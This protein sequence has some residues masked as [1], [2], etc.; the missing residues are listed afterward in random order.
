MP[1]FATAIPGLMQLFTP[2]IRQEAER[3][4]DDDAVMSLDLDEVEAVA[5]VALDDITVGARWVKLEEGW[6]GQTDAVDEVK[7][8]VLCAVLVAAGRRTTAPTEADIEAEEEDF[9]EWLER[10]LSRKVTE[11]E[12]NYLEKVEKRFR[13]V[14]QTGEIFDQDMVRLHP[15][16]NIESM[17][18]L[19]LWPQ[20]PRTLREFWGY[21]ALALNEKGLAVP[22]FLLKAAA[23]DKG[24]RRLAEW[25]RTL[26]L[27]R[28][29]ERVRALARALDSDEADDDEDAAPVVGKAA[30]L[31]VTTSELKLQMVSAAGIF[32][33]VMPADLA[34]LGARLDAGKLPLD[35]A[36]A[37]LLR[38]C[39]EGQRASGSALFR[40]DHGA[41]VRLL[42]AVLAQPELAPRVVTLDGVPLRQDTRALLWAAKEVGDELELRLVQEDG[43]S[44]PMP[45]RVL[46]GATTHYLSDEAVMPGPVWFGDD[47]RV[48]GPLLVPMKALISEDGVLFLEKLGVALP[49]TMAERVVHEPLQVRVRAGCL[50]K[51]ATSGAEYAV[52]Q[53]EAVDGEGRL[54]ERLRGDGWSEAGPLLPND[55]E[56]IILRDRDMLGMAERALTAFRSTFDPEHQGFR[57]RLT[58][59]FPDQFH[60]WAKSLPEAMEL[61][62]DERLQSILADP[63]IARVKLEARQTESIDWFDLR[64]MFEIEGTELKPAEIRRLVAARGGF[65]RLADGS[66]KRVELQLSDE[67][68]VMIDQLGI[69][70]EELGD[71]SHRLHWRQL[72]NEKTA[73]LIHPQAWQAVSR[74]LEAAELMEKPAV[75]KELQLTLRPYQ[76]EGF[77]FLSY[78]TLNRF[79]GILADDMGLG[80]TVQSITWLLWLRGEQPPGE[81]PPPC[82]VVCPKSV[83]D[84]W[85]AEL[86]KTAP[87]LLVQVLREKDELDMVWLTERLDVLVINYAQLRGLIEDLKHVHFLA[88]ILDEGQ[89]IKNPDSQAARAAR[90][91]HAFN[92]LV[93]TG[94]PLENRLLD[95]W[96]LMTFATPGALGDR[97]YFQKHFDR[98]KDGRASAR[99]SARLR[100]FLLRRT[101]GQVAGDLPPRSEEAMIC[102]MTAEQSAAYQAEL[103]RAQQMVLTAAT[104]DALNKNRFAILQ[105]LTRLRQICCHPSLVGAGNDDGAKLTAVLELIEELHAEGHK[106]LLFSQFVRMLTIL[107][108][109]LEKMDI[110][111]HWLTGA[112]NDR[113]SVVKAFQEDEK[114]SVFLLSLK[115]GGSGLNLTAA[116]YV[117]L[118]DPW[119]NPAVEAQAID[120]AHRIGQTQPVMAYR[121]ITKGT[122]EEKILTLQQKKQMM[123]ANILGEEGFSKSLG[124]DDFAYLFDLEREES[125]WQ[126]EL[127][128]VD[129]K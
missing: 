22:R 9:V 69:E 30:R 124:R 118:Y 82:L 20:R 96:S 108:E 10:D 84:V 2:E 90:Q 37:L 7:E 52:L 59:Q 106:V 24:R 41:A 115:A 21:V 114:A 35:V 60:A 109:R 122:I 126:E 62:P 27:P 34:E 105:A 18:P 45:L 1:D 113:A 55:D 6:R 123:S 40:L 13:R 75:P 5:E 54:V 91:I 73:E 28:W 32:M 47:T 95:F 128:G 71:E 70:L 78:L 129:L 57:V 58:R 49:P 119:W 19:V 39:L 107:R 121:M 23:L 117:I 31:M 88:V 87:H 33:T 50:A 92:R 14:R 93:L 56:R 26:E 53:V 72:A 100:P 25:K 43:A 48:E 11:T 36:S 66:W 16:W 38:M 63:L 89:Q 4:V 79:G 83:L 80:K 3:L 85:G 8:L 81:R 102:E 42:L 17:E 46:L 67:Q 15:K 94:T 29:K 120:R 111:C 97:S 125:A 101:K 110:P 77:H 44:A 104:Y 12:L 112:T 99:L 68:Q 64:L 127:K 86:A 116:S 65:V 51:S 103:A 61:L 74:R 76:V 98:R